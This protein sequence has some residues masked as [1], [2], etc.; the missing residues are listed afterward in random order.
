MGP[1]V[2][3]QTA[4]PGKLGNKGWGEPDERKGIVSSLKS[5][6]LPLWNPKAA[7]LPVLNDLVI[8]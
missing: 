2:R 5:Q 8:S 4:A 7:R 6:E 1:R 3:G